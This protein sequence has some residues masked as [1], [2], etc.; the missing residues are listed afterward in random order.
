MRLLSDMSLSNVADEVY[1]A[2]FYAFTQHGCLFPKELLN[3]QEKL[4]V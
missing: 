2:N 4:I 3:L 1:L